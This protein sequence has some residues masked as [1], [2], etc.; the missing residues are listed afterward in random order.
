MQ[1]DRNSAS[2]G[3]QPLRAVF[4]NRDFP[5]IRKALLHYLTSVKDDRDAVHMGA[6]YHRLGR[7][8]EPQKRVD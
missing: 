3:P 2:T 6:L 7:L 1:T 8:D 5:L 4:C